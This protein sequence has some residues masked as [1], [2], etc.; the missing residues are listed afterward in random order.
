MQRYKIVNEAIRVGVPI[1]VTA[2]NIVK[3]WTIDSQGHAIA[4]TEMQ[5]GLVKT[6]IASLKTLVEHEYPVDF[7]TTEPSDVDVRIEALGRYQVGITVKLSPKITTM[8]NNLRGKEYYVAPRKDVLSYLSGVV[9]LLKVKLAA[10]RM[11]LAFLSE[12]V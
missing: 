5:I 2:G 4:K 1:N 12:E 11:H 7:I 6:A 10:E 3:Y 8:V 9:D